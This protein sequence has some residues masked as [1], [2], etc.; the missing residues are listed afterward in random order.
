MYLSLKQNLAVSDERNRVGRELHDTVKQ[1]LF[2][3]GLQLAT[4]K[5]KPA[6]MEAAHEHILEAETITRE[7]QHDL[8]EIITQLRPAGTSDTSLFERIGMIADDFRRRFGV[9][10]ELSHSDCAQ[11]NGHAEHHV[12]RIVQ[13]S[14]MNAVRHGEASKIVIAGKIEHDT[15]TLTIA[16]NGSGFDT[17]EKTGGFGITSMRDRV[18]YLPHGT[19]EIKSSAGVGTEITLSWK[20]ES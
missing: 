5:A 14:L 8:M 4:A 10:I 17:D 19:F 11:A 1:K 2:A 16:D 3:L 13:E 12:L 20:V 18:R 7:A 6:V 9:S 15:T